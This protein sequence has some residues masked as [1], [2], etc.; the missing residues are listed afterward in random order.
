MIVSGELENVPLLDVLQVLAFSSQS[1]ALC[2]ESTDTTTTTTG[3][4]LFDNGGIVCGESPATRLLLARAAREIDPQNRRAFRRVQALACLTELLSLRKG[5]FRFEKHAEPMSE[6]AGV[7]MKSFYAT[8]TMATSELLLVLATAVDKKDGAP[9][10]SWQEPSQARSHPRF[11]P[12]LIEAEL[13]LGTSKLSGYL[14]NMSAGGAF[15]QGDALPEKETVPDVRFELAGGIG[16][17]ATKARVVWTRSESTDGERGVGLAFEGLS[18]ADKKKIHAYLERF[19][20]LAADM[21]LTG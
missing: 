20:Q 21:D 2:I 12:T 4:V 9:M 17:V 5:V 14:T 18:E 19:Q 6:L 13:R 3:T 11:S 16:A 15:F 7:D 1:G 8:G 10:S